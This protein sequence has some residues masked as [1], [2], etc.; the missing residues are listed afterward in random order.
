MAYISFRDCNYLTES[1]L[2]GAGSDA[3][4]NRG[5]ELTFDG[6]AEIDQPITIRL[7]DTDDQRSSA[8]MLINRRYAWRGYGDSHHIPASSRHTTFTAT[9]GEAV[10]GTITLAVDSPTGLAADQL[11]HDE[12][13]M[14]RRMPGAEICELTKFAFEMTGSRPVLAALFHLVMM[15]GQR[16][17]R[18]TDLFI[19]VNP[20]HVRF[21]EAMLGFERIGEVKMNESVAAPAQLMWIKVS[22]IRRRIDELAGAKADPNNRSLYPFFFSKKEENGISA[23]LFSRAEMAALNDAAEEPSQQALAASSSY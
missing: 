13:N 15:Y 10:V 4:A 17:H 14:F 5:V 1:Y 11:F 12:L 9:M 8:R 22:E 2:N 20:R 21:Y 19:E 7:A 23:R 6:N 18:C 16:R 3:G